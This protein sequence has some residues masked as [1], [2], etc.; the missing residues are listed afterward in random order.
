M[1]FAIPFIVLIIS[2][3][4][5]QIIGSMG[6]I[7]SGTYEFT[8]YMLQ[9]GMIIGGLGLIGMSLALWTTGDANLYLPSIPVSYTHLTL[10]TIYSV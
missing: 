4:F 5:L 6:G 3:W 9:Q 1:A 8:T 2:Q 10:P 7:V